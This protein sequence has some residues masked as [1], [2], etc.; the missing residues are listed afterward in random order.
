MDAVSSGSPSL[1]AVIKRVADR[2]LGM[3]ENRLQLLV[4]EA[5]EER[6]RVL[7]KFY[8]AVVTAVLAF[9]G[10]TAWSAAVVVVFWRSNP[11]AVLVILG[12]I[13]NIAAA[14][15]YRQMTGQRE[16]PSLSA[17][18]EQLQKDRDALK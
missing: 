1:L 5:Q 8:L 9:L 16:P 7:S 10:I 13:Y 12:A 15:F 6:D 14:V 17:T 11:V 3:A 18:M 2:L 4:V